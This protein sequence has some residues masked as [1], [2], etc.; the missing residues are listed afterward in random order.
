MFQRITFSLRSP[1]RSFGVSLPYCVV[2][3]FFTNFQHSLCRV[4]ATASL[5]LR[6]RRRRGS[7]ALPVKVQTWC[8][9]HSAARA[10]GALADSE[11]LVS[12]NQPSTWQVIKALKQGSFAKGKHLEGFGAWCLIRVI[13]FIPRAL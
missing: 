11:A 3:F 2:I 12:E 10:Q 4:T 13:T 1:H 5:H 6:R 7:L 9:S 8:W